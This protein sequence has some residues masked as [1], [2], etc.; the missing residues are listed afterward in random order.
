MPKYKFPLEAQDDYKGVIYFTQII[1]TPPTINTGA[2]DKEFGEDNAGI[3]DYVVDI[4]DLFS[5]SFNAG[6]TSRGDTVQLYLPPAQTI[7][8]GVEFDNFS[9]GIAGESARQALSGGESS[10]AGAALSSLTGTGGIG[11][12]LNNLQDPNVAR[13]AAAAAA[14][15]LG[16]KAGAVASSVGQ[17]A[18]NPN[19]RAIFK[20]VRPREHSFNFKF[21]PRSMKEAEEVA[22]IIKWFRTE[23]YPESITVSSKGQSLPVGY[24]FPNKFGIAMRYGGKEVGAKL[25]PCYLRGM[26]TNY[27]ATTMSFFRDGQFSE[28]DL[29]LDM[30]EF[31]TLDKDD[32][33]WGFDMYGKNFKDFWEE[34]WA[35]VTP[36]SGSQ[37]SSYPSATNNAGPQ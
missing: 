18:L 24:K 14:K 29:T 36:S 13:V 1:E 23:I 30:I 10:L 15:K 28:I 11:S 34:L 4:G 3:F 12:I 8:D 35:I 37:N 25:L 26:T 27:N 2:F 7:Q 22:N 6:Y 21:L 33:R 31:R 19:I 20:Q 9:F 32:I 5:S 16:S 17:T